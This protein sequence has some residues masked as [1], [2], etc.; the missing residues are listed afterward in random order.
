MLKIYIAGPLFS[1]ADQAQRYK[2]GKLLREAGYSVFNPVEQPFNTHKE[3]LPTPREIFL[4]DYQAVKECDVVV[5][6]LHGYDE[7][8]VAEIGLAY[9][10][11]KRIVAVDSD[12]RLATANR[13]EIP[14]YGMNHFL[15][16]MLQENGCSLLRHFADA[17]DFLKTLS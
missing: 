6:D 12:I 4:N 17:L 8:V 2:E 16:G 7:G 1:E 11:G 13:Y 10:L 15:L 9:A 5:A 14:T 3:K